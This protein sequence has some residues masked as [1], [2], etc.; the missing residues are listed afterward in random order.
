MSKSSQW[1]QDEFKSINLTDPRLY[2]RFIKV[3]TDLAERPADSINSASS[4]WAAT[5]AAY[6]LFDNGKLESSKI[7]EPHSLATAWRCQS[8]NKIIIAQDT[9]YIDFNKHKKTKGLGKSF[10]NHGQSIKGVCMHS[11][12]ALSPSGLPLGLLYNK[13]WMRKENQ[14]SEAQRLAV[15]M[16]LKESHRWLEC[17]KKSKKL[18]NEQQV[19]VVSDREGDIYEAFEEAYEYSYDVIIRSQH[20]RKLSS[21]FTLLEELSLERVRG[22][23]SVIIP[24]N[25]SRK[26]V[27]AT[28]DIRY[29]KVELAAQPNHAKTQQN[30]MR[31]NTEVYVVDASDVENDLHWRLLTTLPI[32]KLQDA[33]DVLNYYR[34]RWSVELYFKML[35]TGCTIEDCRLGEGG[36]LVKYISL[37]SVV[38]WKLYWMTYVSRQDPNIC[39]ENFL[40]RSEWKAAWWLLHRKRVKEGKMSRDDMPKEPPTLREAI[41]WIAGNGGFLRRKRDGEPGL[42][43]F[44]KGW[45]RV[46]TGAEMFEFFA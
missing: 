45:N 38:A 24:G 21:E 35:K 10:K 1:I 31:T 32:E 11:G 2:K 46:S 14:I 33:K 26:E 4:D 6:R 3:A 7:F 17:G 44:W 12:L 5:K 29:K 42:L 15:P 22:R 19:I 36:K 27:R 25:G 30:K 20:N 13:L 43:T 18:L 9:T 39:C 28:L 16:Q 34:V 41:H 40:M 23:H 8:Y 37:M